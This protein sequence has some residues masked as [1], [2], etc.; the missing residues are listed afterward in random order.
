MGV[1][2]PQPF[3]YQ[4]SE[5]EL[6]LGA[7]N[8]KNYFASLL[9]PHVTGAVLEVGAGIGGTTRVLLDKASVISWH[10]LEPDNDMAT[11]LR[12]KISNGDLPETC[13]VREGTLEGLKNEQGEAIYDAIVYIDVLEHI[14]H[15]EAELTQ[16]ASLLK[17]GG[18]LVVLSPAFGW[19]YSAFD[20]AIGHYRRYDRKSIAAIAPPGVEPVK[21]QYL[22]SVGLMASLGNRLVLKSD[23]PSEKQILFWDRYFVPLSRIM[24]PLF[25]RWFGRSIIAI[26][27]KV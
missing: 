20:K 22:D 3:K 27:K 7:K 4:S 6:F 14:E 11:K 2:A 26:W 1:T 16:A 23:M 18:R 12:Q 9:R 25:G 10:C 19:L 15:D 13:K 5:L 24:D 17:L 8:W 21:T